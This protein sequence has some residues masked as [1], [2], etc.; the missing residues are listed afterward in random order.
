MSRLNSSLKLAM[1]AVNLAFMLA[2][3]GL[4]AVAAFVL[5]SDWGALDPAFYSDWCALLICI[6]VLVLFLACFGWCGTVYQTNRKGEDT[7][8]VVCIVCCCLCLIRVWGLGL[9][10]SGKECLFGCPLWGSWRLLGC[11]AAVVGSHRFL[12]LSRVM[13]AAGLCTGRRMLGTYELAVLAILILQMYFLVRLY[14]IIHAFSEAKDDLSGPGP[15]EYTRF[16]RS[17]ARN[18]DEFYFSAM[19]TCNSA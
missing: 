2:G 9:G 3:V 5:S 4:V 1:F 14:D 6:G 8:I 15:V 11:L 18:F 12:L 19:E 7:G 13:Y 10:F 16:E 17:L